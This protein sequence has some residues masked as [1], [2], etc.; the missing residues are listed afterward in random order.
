MKH[1]LT[2]FTIILSLFIATGCSKDDEP[3]SSDNFC[4]IDGKNFTL[5]YAYLTEETEGSFV[6]F[7]DINILDYIDNNGEFSSNKVMS[8]VVIDFYS[9]TPTYLEI[10]YKVNPNKG[11]GD[12]YYLETSSELSKINFS[13]NGKNVTTNAT[14]ISV[15][16]FDSEEPCEASFA[17]DG[18]MTNVLD[19]VSY[20]ESRGIALTKV[21]DQ[22]QIAFLKSFIR[23][24]KNL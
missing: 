13:I 6:M 5:K 12:A 19:L 8:S 20:S 22:K 18:K 11:S 16:N 7:T 24:K 21:S 14:S 4:K 10:G 17:Y 1:V 9:N 15:F 2:T 3:S 23:S